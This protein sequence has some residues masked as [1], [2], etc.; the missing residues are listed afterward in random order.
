[1]VLARVSKVAR[2]ALS[3]GK[4]TRTWSPTSR[5]AS[6]RSRTWRACQSCAGRCQAK[7]RRRRDQATHPH[8]LLQLKGLHLA[9]VVHR[10]GP[11]WVQHGDWD[12]RGLRGLIE[13]GGE[14][15]EG[16]GFLE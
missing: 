11:F 5:A 14:T 8:N 16:K 2:S 3:R 10:A 13:D 12:Q 15:G 7:G 4:R 9:T 6:T 1:M